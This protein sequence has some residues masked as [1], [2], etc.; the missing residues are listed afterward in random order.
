M[1][2]KLTNHLIFNLCSRRNDYNWFVKQTLLYIT[3][4][5]DKR[6]WLKEM[7]D[8]EIPHHIY[9][10]LVKHKNTHLDDPDLN[11]KMLKKLFLLKLQSSDNI[12]WNND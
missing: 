5:E 2:V 4:V 12:Q 10:D 6:L 8:K 7:L 9:L 3:G 1:K 11:A